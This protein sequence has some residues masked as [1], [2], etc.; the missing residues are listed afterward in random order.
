MTSQ[1]SQSIKEAL[2]QANIEMPTDIY[3]LIFR[4]S[5][6]PTDTTGNSQ[7][8]QPP[9]VKTQGTKNSS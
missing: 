2:Q 4:N 1:V 8:H 3:T 7:S 6:L 9:W 5:P